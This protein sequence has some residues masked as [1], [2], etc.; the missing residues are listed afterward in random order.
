MQLKVSVVFCDLYLLSLRAR[1]VPYLLFSQNISILL[2]VFHCAHALLVCY[3]EGKKNNGVVILLVGI[4]Y[5]CIS[6]ISAGI[7]LH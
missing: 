7:I 4:Y 1:K 5:P 6:A 3:F 2:F